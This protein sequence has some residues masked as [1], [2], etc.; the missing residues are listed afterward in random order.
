MDYD[1]FSHFYTGDTAC[2][3]GAH[4]AAKPAGECADGRGTGSPRAKR[5]LGQWGTDKHKGRDGAGYCVEGDWIC[6]TT[7][8][9]QSIYGLFIWADEADRL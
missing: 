3:C 1:C 4:A 9:S 5:N 8:G 6:Q 2:D 7:E